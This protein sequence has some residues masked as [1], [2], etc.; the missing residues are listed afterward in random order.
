MK[1]FE[2]ADKA[3]LNRSMNIDS[4]M[5]TKALHELDLRQTGWFAVPDNEY[6]EYVNSILSDFVERRL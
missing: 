5:T 2:V 1:A 6:P 4:A 3:L